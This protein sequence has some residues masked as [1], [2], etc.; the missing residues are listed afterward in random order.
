MMVDCDGCCNYRM[1][2]DRAWELCC[3]RIADYHTLVGLASLGCS[4][5]QNLP[6]LAALPPDRCCYECLDSRHQAEE[7]VL[8][9]W[10]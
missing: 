7:V 8:V 5:G 1:A 6:G 9:Q 2:A 3:K 4:F 10:S